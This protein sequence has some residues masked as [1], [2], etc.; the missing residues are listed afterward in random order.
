MRDAYV[1]LYGLMLFTR[2]IMNTILVLTDFSTSANNAAR[3]S[4][5]LADQ[6]D[7]DRILL[8]HSSALSMSAVPTNIADYVPI[9]E[10]IDYDQELAAVKHDLRSLCSS[11]IKIE[12]LNDSRPLSEAIEPI[13]LQE[14]VDL[15][16]I[17]ATEM[18]DLEE[19]L[20][21]GNTMIVVKRS[22][23]PLLVVPKEVKFQI[24][25]NVLLACDL[26]NVAK[27]IPVHTIK[28][29][30]KS[31][32][33]KLFILNV[34]YHEKHFRPETILEQSQ[35]HKA[36]DDESAEFHYI[37]SEDTAQGILNFAEYHHIHLLIA[38]K[39]SRSLL[40]EIFHR[41][42]TKKLI[43]DTG[44]PLLILKSNDFE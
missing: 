11:H 6:L 10:N 27:T 26:E 35:L 40:A 16:V 42:V 43:F 28:A 31:F 32:E 23:K 34:D 15:V 44:I 14:S 20:F 13:I 9:V 25:R 7:A 39:K 29:F 8:Y 30:N 38:V 19:S 22:N 21:G 2:K 17:G 24:I 4:V 5:A 1:K 37:D 18:G 12:T 41:S 3:F 36:F 33:A